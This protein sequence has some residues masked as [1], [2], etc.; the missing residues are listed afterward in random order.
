MLNCFACTL[1]ASVQSFHCAC[2]FAACEA[3]ELEEK[4]SA[5]KHVKMAQLEVTFHHAEETEAIH[6]YAQELVQALYTRAHTNYYFQSCE[7]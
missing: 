4:E 6:L 3:K 7:K 2:D 5:G 1:S